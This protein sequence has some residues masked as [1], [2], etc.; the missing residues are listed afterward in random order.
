MEC[1]KLKFQSFFFYCFTLC[2]YY[3]FF[4]SW[5]I[6][7]V[8]SI[9]MISQG[10]N[11]SIFFHLNQTIRLDDGILCVCLYRE[12]NRPINC[13][14]HLTVFI[15]IIIELGHK[16]PI[17]SLLITTKKKKREK[18]IKFGFDPKSNWI[19]EIKNSLKKKSKYKPNDLYN[20]NSFKCFSWIHPFF[21]YNDNK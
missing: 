17:W 1:L 21:W 14:Y 10:S 18:L 19:G 8:K 15:I 4:V 9:K 12:C 11:I 7:C 3:N 2:L 13:L 20:V 5:S 6:I 16:I